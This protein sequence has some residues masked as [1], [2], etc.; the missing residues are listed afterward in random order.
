MKITDLSYLDILRASKESIESIV[1]EQDNSEVKEKCDIGIILGNESLMGLR[2]DK[3][4]Q[5]YEDGLVDKL[6]VTGGI[7]ILNHDRKTPEADKMH[8]ILRDRGIPDKDIIVE[9]ESHDTN[10]NM[11][12]SLKIISSR[13]SNIDVRK[14]KYAIITSDFHI[15][16]S[17]A[18]F[19]H[20]IGT[21]DNAFGSK[22]LD[23]RTDINSWY[24]SLPTKITIYKEAMTLLLYTRQG[25]FLGDLEMP[26]INKGRSL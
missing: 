9:N 8:T 10:E 26:D 2:C 14:I 23:G 6:V 3:G 12:N 16:R 17:L 7:G 5:L 15:R 25:K 1:Y 24:N 11:I 4:I 21:Y 20:A 19:A 13:Y 18:L 22:V